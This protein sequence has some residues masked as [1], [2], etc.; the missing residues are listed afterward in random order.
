[1]ALPKQV[2]DMK[3]MPYTFQSEELIKEDAPDAIAYLKRT[4]HLD[5]AEALGLSAY[6]KE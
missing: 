5:A 3:K 6:V 4:N 1:M 2:E